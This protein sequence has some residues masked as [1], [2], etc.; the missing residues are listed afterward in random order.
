MILIGASG[1]AKVILDILFKNEITVDRILDANPPVT[2]LFGVPVNLDD[3]AQ[4]SKETKAVIAVGNNLIRKKIAES[5]LLQ[6]MPAV[7][8]RSTVSPFAKIGT[9]TVVMAN[10]VINPDA[11]V[12]KHCIINTGAVIEHD[13]VLEDYVHISPNAALAGNVTV[14]ECSQIGIGAVV[15]QGIKIGNNVTVGAGAVIIRDI[16]DRVTVVGNPGRIIK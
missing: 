14:G 1:H 16:P 10:A 5:R 9:G 8:P 6:Y 12:G 7:H 2:E 3:G 11:L 13:C 15:L 4:L